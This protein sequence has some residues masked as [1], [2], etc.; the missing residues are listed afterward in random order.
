[1]YK[2]NVCVNCAIDVRV[3]TCDLTNVVTAEQSSAIQPRQWIQRRSC[4]TGVVSIK[5]LQN[6][7]FNCVGSDELFLEQNESVEVSAKR[8]SGCIIVELCCVFHDSVRF[9]LISVVFK[10]EHQKRSTGVEVRSWIP[11]VEQQKK[12]RARC[13][14]NGIECAHC[15]EMGI[16]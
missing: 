4:L 8:K 12:I 10:A 14:T 9:F 2:A 13:L 3:L 1:M 16:L 5:S 6:Q 11:L 7:G 15:F